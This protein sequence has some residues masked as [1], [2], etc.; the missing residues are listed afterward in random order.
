MSAFDAIIHNLRSFITREVE[1]R[2]E[3]RA[4]AYETTIDA[5]IEPRGSA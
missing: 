1:D 3:K 4:D 2:L 5:R